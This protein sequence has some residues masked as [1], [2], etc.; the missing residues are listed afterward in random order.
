MN[1]DNSYSVIWVFYNVDKL[2]CEYVSTMLT[3]ITMC[4]CKDINIDCIIL[5]QF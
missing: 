1:F 4:V 5:G 3:C 2:C